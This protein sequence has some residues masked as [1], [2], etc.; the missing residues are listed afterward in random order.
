MVM[1]GKK[2]DAS[3]EYHDAMSSTVR[4]S[5]F[6][7]FSEPVSS[8]LEFF[9]STSSTR[10][11]F[12]FGGCAMVELGSFHKW[13]KYVCGWKVLR[14]RYLFGLVLK[15]RAYPESSFGSLRRSTLS[16]GKWCVAQAQAWDMVQWLRFP[17]KGSVGVL[18]MFEEHNRIIWVIFSLIITS[19]QTVTGGTQVGNLVIDNYFWYI[20]CLE[21]YNLGT[22]N[23]FNSCWRD[24]ESVLIRVFTDETSKWCVRDGF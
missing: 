15:G 22:L 10:G 2:R 23:F 5:Q 6:P 14:C 1:T 17:A 9:G 16:E 20:F 21:N 13:C 19:G 18:N 11:F 24:I 4:L 7:C 3:N 8:Q 12:A